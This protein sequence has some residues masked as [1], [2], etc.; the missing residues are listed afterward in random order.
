MLHTIS[1]VS[2]KTGNEAKE[3]YCGRNAFEHFFYVSV[4]FEGAMD[5][6]NLE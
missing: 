5:Q 1:E 2:A 6:H 4:P 3:T